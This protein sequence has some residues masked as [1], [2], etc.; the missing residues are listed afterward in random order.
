M[1]RKHTQQHRKTKNKTMR[2]VVGDSSKAVASDQPAVFI[3][4]NSYDSIIYK[5][6]KIRTSGR[7]DKFFCVLT[8]SYSLYYCD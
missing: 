4:S 2:I 1:M 7:E 3:Q 5:N 6:A 8:T